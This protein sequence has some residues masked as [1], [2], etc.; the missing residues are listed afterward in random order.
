MI[1]YEAIRS[2]LEV[3]LE[4]EIKLGLEKDRYIVQLEQ[5]KVNNFQM[6]NNWLA[7]TPNA[8]ADRTTLLEMEEN[9]K[10][11]LEALECA[12]KEMEVLR[13]RKT[14]LSGANRALRDEFVKKTE[15]WEEKLLKLQKV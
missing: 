6:A 10:S 15:I 3:E 7:S 8:S 12:L 14:A 13:S 5:V 4:E 11:T 1:D 2:C 9:I